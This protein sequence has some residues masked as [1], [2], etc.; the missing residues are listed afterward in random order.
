MFDEEKMHREGRGKMANNTD[1]VKR[2][3]GSEFG[4]GLIGKKGV[5]VGGE[6]LRAA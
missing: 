4:G 5:F 1:G 6:R 2:R 3:F